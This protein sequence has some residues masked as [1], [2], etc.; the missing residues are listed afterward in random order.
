MPDSRDHGRPGG[1]ADARLTTAC[2]ARETVELILAV[3]G[4]VVNVSGRQQRWRI[5]T[6]RGHVLTFRPEFV[7]AITPAKRRLKETAPA[8]PPLAIDTAVAAVEAPHLDGSAD[9]V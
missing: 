1:Q 6:Q 5:R 9:S 7:V 2:H 3:R 8:R 4:R